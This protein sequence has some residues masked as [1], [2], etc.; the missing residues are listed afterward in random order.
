MRFFDIGGGGIFKSQENTLL[1]NAL[2]YYK[3]NWM[4]D[5]AK[6]YSEELLINGFSFL[7]E[8]GRILEGELN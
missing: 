7:T 5:H 3:M 1:R 6:K 4:C 8:S 2:K